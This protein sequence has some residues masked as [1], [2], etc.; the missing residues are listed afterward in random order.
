M[1]PIVIDYHVNTFGSQFK[2]D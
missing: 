1:G 2:S